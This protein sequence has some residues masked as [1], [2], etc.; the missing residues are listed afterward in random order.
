MQIGIFGFPKTGKTTLFNTLTG[1]DVSMN[2]YA[3]RLNELNIG[4]TKVPDARLTKLTSMFKPKKETHAK[5]EYLDI[6]GVTKGASSEDT[7]LNELKE[8]DLLLHVVR[9]FEDPNL[10]HGQGE[11]DP[12]RDIEN[13]ELELILADL[14]VVTR[15]IERLEANLKKIPREQDKK[16]LAALEKCAATL[17][18]EKPLRELDLSPDERKLLRG[19]TFLS[20]KPL[21]IVLNLSEHEVD[22]ID[23]AT[24]THALEDF[25]EKPGVA[26]VPVSAKIEMEIASL[27]PADGAAFMRDLGIE[28]SA[29]H[30]LIHTSYDFLNL[31]SFFTV[32]EDECRAWTIRKGTHAQRAART[33]H[34]DLERGFI[35]AEVIAFKDLIAA[36]SWNGAKKMGKFRLEGK[37]YPVQDGDILN[38]RFNV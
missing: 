36:N 37:T 30:R 12:K 21:L 23:S 13:M 38:V 27:G 5:V 2:P 34:S 28:E 24:E 26:I 33:I 9:A 22:T 14:A 19:F 17:E 35:R 11:I 16:E 4:M 31:I 6:A 7:F 18:N 10:V 15:R 8:M 25:S 29:L 32:G 20:G 3:T 1:S